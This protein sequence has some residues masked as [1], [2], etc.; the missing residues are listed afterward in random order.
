MVRL[1]PWCR[2][3]VAGRGGTALACYVL[4]G[5][6]GPCLETVDTLCRLRLAIRRLGGEVSVDELA[7]ALAELLELTGLDLETKLSR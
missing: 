4:Q 7:P 1:Q 2:V 3:T 6:G 5:P